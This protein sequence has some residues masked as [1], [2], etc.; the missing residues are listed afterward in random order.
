MSKRKNAFYPLALFSYNLSTYSFSNRI[1]FYYIDVL[2]LGAAAI[3]VV[4]LLFGIWNAI[5]DPLMGQLTD[6]TRSRWGRRIPYLRFGAIPLAI[7]FFLMWTPVTAT[8]WLTIAYFLIAI[9]VFDTLST[10]LFA[11]FN[12]LFVEITGTLKE[13]A[14][15]A[16]L[17]ETAGGVGLILA[18]ILAPILSRRFGYPAMGAIIGVIVLLGYVGSTLR[19]RE[20]PARLEEERVGFVESVRRALANRPF[21][22]FLGAALM[23][24]FC[25]ITLSATVPFWYKYALAIEGDATLLGLRLGPGV[26]EAALLAVPF[27]LA[28]PCLQI[29]RAVAARIGPRRAWIGASL[30]WIPGLLVIYFARGFGM[31]VLGTAL[32]APGMAG[33]MMLFVMTLSEIADYD[34]ARTGQHREGSLFGIAGLFMRLAFSVQAILFAL[35]LEPSG[36]IADAVS[37]PAGAVAAIR[38]IMALAPIAACLLCAACL[39]AMRIPRVGSEPLPRPQPAGAL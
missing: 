19:I 31:G 22:W 13:R 8:S 24:E 20:N 14:N 11:S 21:R 16:A 26:Q 36:Y 10:L 34:A 4:W 15:L 38:A 2:G 37:Q 33:F 3:S 23:R 6:R 32:I 35:L 27:V 25:F 9:F 39:A 5:N 30:A 29:W 17:R 18:F 7:A 28:I 12:A 1:Q